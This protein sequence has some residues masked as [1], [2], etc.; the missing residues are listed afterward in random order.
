ME[1]MTLS[2]AFL[3]EK[4]GTVLSVN[5]CR[6]IGESQYEECDEA[7]KVKCVYFSTTQH[8]T[9]YRSEDKLWG[10]VSSFYQ[11]GPRD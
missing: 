4:Q 3:S 5:M 9:T 10:S 11:V 6:E 7:R 2:D 1:A 8:S